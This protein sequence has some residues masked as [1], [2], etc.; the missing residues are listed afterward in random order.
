MTG[1]EPVPSGIESDRYVSVPLYRHLANVN[2]LKG[3]INRVLKQ[4]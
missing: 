1:F 3:L 2:K 4:M